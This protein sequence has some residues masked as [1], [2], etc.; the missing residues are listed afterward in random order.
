MAFC[1]R[2]S[3]E[4]G[5]GPA[6][7]GSEGSGFSIEKPPLKAEFWSGC[8]EGLVFAPMAQGLAKGQ[9]GPLSQLRCQLCS[10]LRVRK[11][12]AATASIP[13]RGATVCTYSL[14]PAPLRGPP[15]PEGKGKKLG[16]GQNPLKK[17][18]KLK[19]CN[20]AENPL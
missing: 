9:A 10:A 14:I 3:P 19:T 5:A 16:S 11:P 13:F 8:S 2:G 18:L 20:T 12:Q 1:K 4:R 17:N 15:S 7:A 6:N